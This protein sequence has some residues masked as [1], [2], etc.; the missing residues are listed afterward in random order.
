MASLLVSEAKA[1]SSDQKNTVF[2]ATLDSQKAFEVINHSILLDKL[3]DKDINDKVWLVIK[4]LYQDVSSKVK[5]VGGLS[6]SFPMN[7]GVR[8][9]GIL[10]THLY[11]IYIDELLNI[12]KS[13]V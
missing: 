10:S 5:W 11:K 8:Q 13:S 2:M 1:E 6:D 4:D 7:Q 12:L 9:G 3:F